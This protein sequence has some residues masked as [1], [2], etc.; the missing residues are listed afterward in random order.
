LST[1]TNV[2]NVFVNPSIS[3]MPLSFHGMW[4]DYT[5]E[6]TIFRITI[7]I[8]TAR[9]KQKA[10]NLDPALLFSRHSTFTGDHACAAHL[11]TQAHYPGS[12]STAYCLLIYRSTVAAKMPEF[13]C[14]RGRC[15]CALRQQRLHRRG[16]RTDRASQRGVTAAAPR[17]SAPG[18]PRHRN[19]WQ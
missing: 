9:T 11:A 1:A 15:R 5:T 13:R 18:V 4:K 19:P 2:S 10:R 3:I 6:T 16:P 12:S 17:A 7:G 14:C 8:F